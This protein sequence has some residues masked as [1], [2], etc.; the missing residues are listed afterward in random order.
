MNDRAEVAKLMWGM[1]RMGQ[2]KG[3]WTRREW[4]AKV[5]AT[6]RNLLTNMARF[7]QQNGT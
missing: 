3:T 6:G 2:L 4:Y 1:R 5:R 7:R